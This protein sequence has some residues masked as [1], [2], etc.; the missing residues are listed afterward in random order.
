MCEI[1]GLVVELCKQHLASFGV[2]WS[3]P[4]L[5]LLIGDGVAFLEQHKG[6]PFDVI[7]VDGSDPVGPAEGLIA[8]AFY[9]SCKR[10]LSKEGSLVVQS[11]SPIVMRDDLVRIVTNMRAVFPSVQTYLGPVPIYPSGSWSYTV[12]SLAGDPSAPRAARVA[13]IES[14]CKLYNADLHRAAFALPNDLRTALRP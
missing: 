10:C 11:E 8:S 5:E 3:D 9:A 12:G 13:A 7:I 2:P 6:P 4:R 14:Q 1:D